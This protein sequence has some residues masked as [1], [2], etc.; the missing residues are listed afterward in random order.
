[1]MNEQTAS[2]TDE[3]QTVTEVIEAHRKRM[4]EIRTNQADG[5]MSLE[6]AALAEAEEIVRFRKVLKDAV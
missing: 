3:K 2:G 1:M 5:L 4:L 6:K